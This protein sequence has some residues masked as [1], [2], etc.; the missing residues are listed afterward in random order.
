MGLYLNE[1][2]CATFG[3]SSKTRYMR[4]ATQISIKLNNEMVRSVTEKEKYKYLGMLF[5]G[6]EKIDEAPIK[7]YM[8]MHILTTNVIPKILYQVSKSTKEN[9][10]KIKNMVDKYNRATVRKWLKLH[11]ASSS[12]QIHAP[13]EK[14]GFGVPMIQLK[15]MIR[16]HAAK[17]RGAPNK[18]MKINEV[19]TIEPNNDPKF[20]YLGVNIKSNGTVEEITNNDL[21]EMIEKVEKSKLDGKT[22]FRLMERYDESR[23]K[24]TQWT[25]SEIRPE[26]AWSSSRFQERR[27]SPEAHKWWLW[28]NIHR[29]THRKRKVQLGIKNDQRPIIESF[30]QDRGKIK[31]SQDKDE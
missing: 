25:V 16:R 7:P 3:L 4:T 22:K 18:S 26:N 10:G 13:V 9:Y 5:N 23:A 29:R 20:K 1:K 8:K 24:A 31:N 17:M 30:F 12:A 15:T 6:K 11:K 28:C 14:G 2:K 21:K 27:P 19:F